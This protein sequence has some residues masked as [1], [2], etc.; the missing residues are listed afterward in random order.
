VG[1][2]GIIERLR[3]IDL[4]RAGGLGIALAID[5]ELNF[6]ALALAQARDIVDV[7]AAV[8]IALAGAGCHV[9]GSARRRP[10][11]ASIFPCT[12]A[13]RLLEHSSIAGGTSTPCA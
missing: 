3:E 4:Q 12:T 13:R 8:A 11:S 2:E 1:R 9:T 5:Q 10:C 6:A 7:Q